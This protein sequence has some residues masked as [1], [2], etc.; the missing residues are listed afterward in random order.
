MICIS[1]L[2]QGADLHLVLGTRTHTT[3]SALALNV[4]HHDTRYICT[5]TAVPGIQQEQQH[6]YEH[7]VSYEYMMD[8]T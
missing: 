6:E 5:A 4:T 8:F 1:D 3:V 2:R 7:I